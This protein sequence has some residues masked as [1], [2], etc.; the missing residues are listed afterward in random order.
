MNGSARY[1]NAMQSVSQVILDTLDIDEAIIDLDLAIA[2]IEEELEALN[3]C[4]GRDIN[5]MLK[6]QAETAI[7]NLSTKADTLAEAR[8]LL[9]SYQ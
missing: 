8:T 5:P 7:I 1:E 2:T 3:A 4:L 6:L 9:R